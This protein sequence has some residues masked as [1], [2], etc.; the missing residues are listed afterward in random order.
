MKQIFLL[1]I[2]VI[3]LFDLSKFLIYKGQKLPE[4]TQMNQ[5]FGEGTE[6]VYVAAGDST[7][8]GIGATKEKNTYTYSVAENLANNNKIIYQNIGV[9]GAQT[10]DVIKKQLPQIIHSNPQIVTISIG[11]NDATH[12]RSASSIIENY[13]MIKSELLDKTDADIYISNIP[14]LSN[15][16]IL[17]IWFR[18]LL[19]RKIVE[20]NKEIDILE[21]ERF[22]IVDI[23]SSIPYTPETYAR[24]QFHPSDEGY[25]N[26][27]RVYLESISS[28]TQ[29]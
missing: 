23:Y 4:I 8:L 12:L 1:A 6:L 24:D 26:W 21:S 9:S 20:T 25:K 22:H 15:A 28:K 2:G 3:L 11:A 7:A 29:F 13:Q 14:S 5:A 19:D 17:P 18:K 16:S 27:A 10:I